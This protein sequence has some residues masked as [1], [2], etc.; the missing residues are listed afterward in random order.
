MSYARI[1]NLALAAA[2]LV[3]LGGGAG[4]GFD[5]WQ[6]QRQSL[7]KAAALTGGDP[8]AAGRRSCATAARV[9]TRFRA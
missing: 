9:A 2:A 8:T 4:F 1:R 5:A 7:R 3:I 6:E